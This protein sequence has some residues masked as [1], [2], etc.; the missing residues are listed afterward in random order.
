MAEAAGTGGGE[1][2]NIAQ[3]PY[4]NTAS[5]DRAGG[6]SG[7]AGGGEHGSL[8]IS[9]KDYIDAQDEKTR[10]Q[11]DAQF[12]RIGSKLDNLKVPSIGQIAGIIFV[13]VGFVFAILA[14]ASDRFDGGLSAS[15]MIH[16]MKEEQHGRDNKQ[17]LRLNRLL[18]I[19]EKAVDKPQGKP[20]ARAKLTR[21][22]ESARK[23]P[24]E[25]WIS[26]MPLF[27]VLL[28]KPGNQVRKHRS[29]ILATVEPELAFLGVF[30]QMLGRHAD[31]RPVD[32]PF[33]LREKAF[34]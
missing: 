9:M 27:S 6:S 4:A 34:H 28:G 21:S 24:P 19:V 14:Y 2:S 7:G 11:N 30:A 29:R 10:A 23:T 22:S 16:G 20:D 31:V 33:Q 3:L 8:E 5:N 13:A 26:W 1:P 17:D 18:A 32:C 25:T 12:V 15:S